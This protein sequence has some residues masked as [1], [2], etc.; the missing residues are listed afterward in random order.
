[1]SKTWVLKAEADAQFVFEKEAFIQA[2]INEPT[3][4]QLKLL[5]YS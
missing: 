4:G 3:N 5:T 1:M 2:S